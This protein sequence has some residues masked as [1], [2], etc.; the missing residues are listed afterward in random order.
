MRLGDDGEAMKA[1]WCRRE[2][3]S[4]A[5]EGMGACITGSAF[6]DLRVGSEFAMDD[7]KKPAVIIVGAGL[8]GLACARALKRAGVS[9]LIVEAA[10][11]VGGRIRTDE[12]DGFRLDRGFQVFLPAYPEAKRVL[13]YHELRLRPFY[14]GADVMIQNRRCRLADPLHHPIDAVKRS[15]CRLTPW[16]EIWHTVLLK[17][18]IL[19]LR[20]VPRDVP[21]METEDYLKKMGFS[22]EFVDRFFRPFFGGVFL[23]KDLRTS[24]RMFEFIFAMFDQGGAAVP[25]RGMQAIPDQLASQLPKGSIRLNAPVAAIREHSVVLENGETIRA[26]HIVLAVDERT[27]AR[28]LNAEKPPKPARSVTC[29]YFATD[30]PV[31]KEPILHLDGSGRGPVNNAVVM[32]RVSPYYAP[33]GKHLISVSVIGSAGGDELESVVRDQ[34]TGWFGSSVSDWKLIRTYTVREAQSEERQL[35]VGDESVPA[36]IRPGLHRCGDYCEDIS[37]NGALISGRRAAEAVLGSLQA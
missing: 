33:E 35:T 8:A 14:R 22:P 26:H 30:Q 25:E 11:S 31:P 1:E 12:V 7:E 29:L 18:E 36:T 37:I 13:D 19:G 6:H 24:S 32:S 23:E 3:L 20:K 16:K 2:M 9:F 34:M 15:W 4:Q 5:L 27:A 28:L 21:E 17:K 10:D